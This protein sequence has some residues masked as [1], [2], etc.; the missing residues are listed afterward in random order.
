MQETV[1]LMSLRYLL[2]GIHSSPASEVSSTRRG[3]RTPEYL[4]S[5]QWFVYDTPSGSGAEV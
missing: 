5:D 1:A 4:E 2:T 3:I